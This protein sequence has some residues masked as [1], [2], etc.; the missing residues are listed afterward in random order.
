MRN[1]RWWMLL[2][3]KIHH[4]EEKKGISCSYSNVCSSNDFAR[5]GLL[6]G[7]IAIGTESF[8]WTSPNWTS[9]GLLEN[10]IVGC[11]HTAC[12]GIDRLIK[13]DDDDDDETDDETEV[14]FW[15]LSNVNDWDVPPMNSYSSADDDI[16]GVISSLT[17]E[18]DAVTSTTDWIESVGFRRLTFERDEYGFLP[19]RSRL[20][21][22][23]SDGVG[24][25]CWE[26]ERSLSLAIPLFDDWSLGLFACV[27]FLWWLDF[28][29]CQP[30]FSKSPD[31]IRVIVDWTL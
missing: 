5:I 24:D 30:P 20:L 21:P 10:R 22:P 27:F 23:R 9:I 11:I 15:L 17:F 7:V 12:W 16:V 14:F 3:T 19:W 13:T 25:V 4:Q 1:I 6:D 8:H 28:A 2:S 18:E 29:V 26:R 31:W